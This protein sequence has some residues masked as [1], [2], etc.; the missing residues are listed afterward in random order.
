MQEQNHTETAGL[1]DGEVE[2]P[3]QAVGTEAALNFRS[4]FTDPVEELRENDGVVCRNLP[5]SS[6]H[7]VEDREDVLI[8][9]VFPSEHQLVHE[10]LDDEEHDWQN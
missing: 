2:E 4:T 8:H 9:D 6:D 1:H 3:E 10:K 5:N 7:G